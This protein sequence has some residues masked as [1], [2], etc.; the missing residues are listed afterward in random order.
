LSPALAGTVIT[1]EIKGYVPGEESGTATLY[2]DE[3]RCRMEFKG[4]QSHNFMIYAMDDD[5]KPVLYLVDQHKWTYIELKEKDLKKIKGQLSD[6]MEQ[7]EAYMKNMDQA[8]RDQMKAQ[9]GK[10]IERMEKI[11]SPPDPAKYEFEGG[12]A[13][14]VADWDT[15]HFKCFY[16]EELENEVWVASWADAGVTLD[17]MT[18]LS[19]MYKD[20][21]EMASA[22]AFFHVMWGEANVEGFPVRI[23]GY[24]DGL[25]SQQTIVQNIAKRDLEDD[26]FV[27]TKDY[28][29]QNFMEQ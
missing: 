15:Q 4:A 7:M 11:L 13:A 9:F 16:E 1:S 18:V 20:F 3:N 21:G 19:A 14:K 10:Q 2:L 22:A 8:Q 6:Q 26:L 27:V 12:E 25:K 28:D 23:M 29:K 5:K 24:R 17:D